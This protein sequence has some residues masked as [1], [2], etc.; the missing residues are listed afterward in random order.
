[1]TCVAGIFF[2]SVACV[3]VTRS[4]TCVALRSIHLDERCRRQH[5]A[6]RDVQRDVRC[7]RQR[8]AQ[9][10]VRC[11]RQRHAQ[12]D[13]RC[14]RQRHAQRDVRCRRQRHAQRDV[15]CRRQRHAQRDVRCLR[16]VA[17]VAYG[18]ARDAEA[19][20]TSQKKMIIEHCFGGGGD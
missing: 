6:Q 18:N 4:V 17:V 12:R 15:R 16:C 10:D 9:R 14:R 1:V 8:H 2:L 7:R 5:Q 13:V 3:A 19:F 11:H 20:F